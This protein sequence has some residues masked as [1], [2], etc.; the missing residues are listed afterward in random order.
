M[1]P[2][3]PYQICTRCVMDTSDP[4][5]RFDAN[6]VCSH[7]DEFDAAAKAHWHRGPVGREKLQRLV[8]KIKE[9]GKGND[10]DVVIGVS[11]GVD[12][13][14]LLHLCKKE[15]ALRPI[16]VH[17]DAGW[18]SDL[19]VSNIEKIV[20]KLQIDLYTHVV[21]WEEMKDLQRA[22]VRSGVA[23]LD[24]PQDHI[25]IAEVYRTAVRMKVR[26]IA[27]GSN[28]ATESILPHAWGYDA[29]DGRQLR[30]I[31]RQFGDRPLRQYKT[32]SLLQR[33]IIIPYLHRVTALYPLNYIDYNK[34]EAMRLLE[35]EYGWVY[36]GGK[37]YESRWTRFF[38]SYLLPRRYGYDKRR[39]HLASLVVT[40]EMTREV[41]M[42][43]LVSPPYDPQEIEADIDFVCRKLD[44]KRAEFESCLQQP[45]R[46]FQDYPNN[47]ALYK[48]IRNLLQFLA[49]ARRSVFPRR[50]AQT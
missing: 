45:L 28:L 22:Y 34:R 14:Y 33:R 12:S 19:A 39:A 25:F 29:S 15:L 43:E 27:N 10:Y 9:N 42:Q 31:H 13:S 5:I 38:Q 3:A 17:I 35:A 1:F 50:P 11:G 47:A 16:A 36:Y 2:Q 8:E 18:N 49:A 26:H 40:G 37:H 24:V 20:K 48:Q 21:D 4:E 6:G 41:A 44:M 30:A 46:S 23:N 7:C 32:I